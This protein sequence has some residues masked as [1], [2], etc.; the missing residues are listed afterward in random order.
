[1]ITAAYIFSI[2]NNPGKGITVLEDS[3]NWLHV[4]DDPE[5]RLFFSILDIENDLD[6]G[7]TLVRMKENKKQTL[8]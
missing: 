6:I 7:L 4:V 3:D 5:N 1:M 8:N 2:N